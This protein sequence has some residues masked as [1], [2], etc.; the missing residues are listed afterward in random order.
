MKLRDRLMNLRQIGSVSTFDFRN[1]LLRL[2]AKKPDE[3]T[4]F[5][6]FLTGLKANVRDKVMMEKTPV[7]I[8]ELILL[9]ERAD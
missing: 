8:E 4:A 7:G 9:A 1:L 3:D 6:L 2:G 5:H